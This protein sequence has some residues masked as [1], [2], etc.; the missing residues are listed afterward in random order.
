MLPDLHRHRQSKIGVFPN[1]DNI[2]VLTQNY[3]LQTHA[4]LC[5][6]H[7]TF[8][9]DGTSERTENIFSSTDVVTERDSA[10]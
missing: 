7:S 1:L 9:T 8:K 6:Q 5:N 4:A 3:Q 10:N 2:L